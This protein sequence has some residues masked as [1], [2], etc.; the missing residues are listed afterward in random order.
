[1]N[2]LNTKFF[3]GSMIMT[4]MLS[5]SIKLIAETDV[6]GYRDSVENVQAN[7]GIE[8]LLYKKMT[9]ENME[10]FSLRNT[11]SYPVKNIKGVINYKTMEGEV[12]HSQ[13]FT[14]N[15]TIA[16]GAAKL[17]SL[18]SFDQKGEYSFHM[19]FD[20][21]GVPPGVIAYMVD[22]KILSFEPVN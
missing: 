1:M 21:R 5:F 22:L 12:F 4:L 8:L 19:N 15:Q 16:P 7:K 13:E 17:T 2:I 20:P 10:H 9:D 14:I 6:S 11:N 18:N 3:T